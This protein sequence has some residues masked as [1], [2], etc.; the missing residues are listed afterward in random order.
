[1]HPVKKGNLFE[2]PDSL[3]DAEVFESL[4][5]DRGVLIER[6]ISRGQATPKGSWYDQKR[7]EWVALLQGEATL[8]YEDG[9]TLELKAGDFVLIPAHCRH[10][11]ERTSMH[12]PCVWI[13]VHGS[14][15]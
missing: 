2:L 9:T 1:M 14:L 15:L 7:D 8:A 4:I 12:P 5:P 3:P 6:I 11:V 13:A 10:R